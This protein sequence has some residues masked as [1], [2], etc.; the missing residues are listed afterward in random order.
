M[1]AIG[2][3]APIVLPLIPAILTILGL[4]L[5]TGGPPAAAVVLFMGLI[6]VVVALVI[7][8]GISGMMFVRHSRWTK[9]MR[10]L[11]AADGIKAGEVKWFR[12]E[13]KTEEKRALKSMSAA[14]ELLGD[15]YLETLASRLTA[16]RVLK[17]TKREMMQARR[18]LSS[19][20]R[21]ES[22]RAVEIRSAIETDLAHM[23]KINEEAKTML[24]E[25]ESRLRLIETTAARKGTLAGSELALKRLNDRAAELPL[26]LESARESQLLAGEI[27]V[28]LAEADKLKGE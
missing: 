17:T 18:R 1:K 5:S 9:E 22:S 21:H 14:D 27:A 26:A 15:A 19:V 20:S 12:N 23:A 6:S 3:S 28:E 24:A 2:I 4:F 11:I 7:G 8:L 16:T 10:E 13:L 25:A